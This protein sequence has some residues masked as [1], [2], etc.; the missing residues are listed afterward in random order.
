MPLYPEG[1][2]VTTTDE[3]NLR[4]GPSTDSNAIV[5]LPAGT[6]LQITG[7][8]AEAGQCDWWPVTVTET[9]QAGYIIEQ[10]L[11]AVSPQ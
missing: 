6:Q 5:V 2:L 9:G 3:V 4:D 11:K 7:A 10:Y 8:F 1:T